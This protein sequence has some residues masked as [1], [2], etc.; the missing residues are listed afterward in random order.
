MTSSGKWQ[1]EKPKHE[2]VL[3]HDSTLLCSCGTELRLAGADLKY[4]Q[5]IRYDLLLDSHS[6]HKNF[7]T[8][9]RLT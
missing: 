9:R 5:R 7:K 6:R 3:M 4:S 8:L 2:I 1:R